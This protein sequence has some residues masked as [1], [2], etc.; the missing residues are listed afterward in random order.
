MIVQ[1]FVPVGLPLAFERKLAVTD[2]WMLKPP[3]IACG[4][5]AGQT[6]VNCLLP[7][8]CVSVEVNRVRPG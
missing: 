8:S 2:P 4:W 1:A 6:V 5:A 7:D 3:E